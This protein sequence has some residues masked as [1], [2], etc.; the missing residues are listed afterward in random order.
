MCLQTVGN[1]FKNTV[2]KVLMVH[3]CAYKKYTSVHV[4]VFV[5]MCVHVRVC[6]HVYVHVYAY[7]YVLVQVRVCQGQR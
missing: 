4:P 5:C 6:V 1:M 7:V 3:V 2:A